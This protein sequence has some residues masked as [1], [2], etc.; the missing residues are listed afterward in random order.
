MRITNAAEKGEVSS[1]GFNLVAL[2]FINNNKVL[3]LR[4]GRPL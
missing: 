2:E 1:Y 4:E 3:I